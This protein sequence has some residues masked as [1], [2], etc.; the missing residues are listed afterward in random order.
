M[1][2]DS[3]LRKNSTRSVES[4]RSK[5]WAQFLENNNHNSSNAQYYYNQQHQQPQ[6]ERG[7]PLDVNTQD[8]QAAF[9][10]QTARRF[11]HGWAPSNVN[12]M[13]DKRYDHFSVNNMKAS[14]LATSYSY[15]D[16]HM[17]ALGSYRTNQ[18]NNSNTGAVNSTTTANTAT[19]SIAPNALP[20][21]ICQHFSQYGIC[22][23]KEQCPYS[24]IPSVFL[25]QQNNLAMNDHA[26]MMAYSTNTAPANII[27]TSPTSTAT[28]FF[29]NQQ[30][31]PPLRYSTSASTVNMDSFYDTSI[32]SSNSSL[33]N[34]KTSSQ[35]IDNMHHHQQ[36][37]Q[38]QQQQQRR[39]SGSTNTDPESNKYTGASLEEFQGKLYEL[40]K[41]QNGC[42]F[43][44]TK[45]EESPLNVAII[46]GEI[47]THF[48]DLMTDPF[49]NYLCQKL[50]ERCDDAQR[51]SIV[52]VIAPEFLKIC[53]SMHGTR[54]VQKLIEFL[55]TKKQVCNIFFIRF[56]LTLVI[57]IDT[58]SYCSTS[59]QRSGID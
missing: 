17:A 16:L 3:S 58:S 52:D 4:L 41:D 10:S 46:Y 43:L 31:Q 9:Y 54:A 49:G 44:Q 40:C 33:F 23:L 34:I 6:Q 2:L 18:Y 29:V 53:L 1:D 57:L 22:N 13:Q 20:K 42:R 12:Q 36:Q 35:V 24:H 47:H 38:Q 55:S 25:Q 37:Q 27:T 21:D 39:T 15:S 59:T 14:R 26:A 7:G 50:L 19:T 56:L 11:S 28:N 32:G 8:V 30:Q 45:L 48:V 5:S 51:T